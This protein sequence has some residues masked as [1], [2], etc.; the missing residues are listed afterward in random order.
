M[1]FYV[2]E[3]PD[4]EKAG[5][6]REMRERYSTDIPSAAPG[7]TNDAREQRRIEG[8]EAEEVKQEFPPTVQAAK[9]MCS[10]ARK[11]ARS[12]CIETSQDLIPVECECS[13]RVSGVEPACHLYSR[14]S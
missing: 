2:L 7:N 10:R 13:I 8:G 12:L 11:P 3:W 6:E 14:W 5:E 1:Y 9:V 4:E